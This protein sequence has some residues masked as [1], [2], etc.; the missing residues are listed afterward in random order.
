[1]C[2]KH[3]R[4]ASLGDGADA[5]TMLAVAFP[6][7]QVQILPYN[8]TVK[9]LG[10][11]SSDN[12]MRAVRDRFEVTP[13][14]AAPANRSEIS[15]YFDG[16][17]NNLKPHVRASTSD[18]IGSLDVSVLQEELLAPILKIADV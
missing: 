17:W 9:D 12:F 18:P 13:G 4:G 14:A 11:L 7:D 15:M 6:H 8:R 16:H 3:L 10:D 2:E 5:S 1:M